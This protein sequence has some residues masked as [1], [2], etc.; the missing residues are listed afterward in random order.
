M[1]KGALVPSGSF[2]QLHAQELVYRIYLR[3]REEW[4]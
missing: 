2:K 3:Q 4:V 1:E